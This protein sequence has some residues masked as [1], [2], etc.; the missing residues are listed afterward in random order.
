LALIGNKCC[1]NSK[2]QRSR[3]FVV[4]LGFNFFESL[5]LKKWKSLAD[6]RIRNRYSSVCEKLHIPLQGQKNPVMMHKYRKISECK[7]VFLRFDVPC[8]RCYLVYD[9]ICPL[10]QFYQFFLL[11]TDC[12]IGPYQSSFPFFNL[13]VY[14]QST[15][16]DLYTATRMQHRLSQQIRPKNHVH[17]PSVRMD[18]L[19]CVCICLWSTFFLITTESDAA[20]VLWSPYYHS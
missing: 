3:R 18:V 16:V 13:R 2:A 6:G 14:L 1:P 11:Y 5:I 9:C 20:K 17:E 12:T 8:V 15:A 7:V 4:V 10:R 19:Y